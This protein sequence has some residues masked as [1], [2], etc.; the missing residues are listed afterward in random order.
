V[1]RVGGGGGVP[2]DLVLIDLIDKS[3]EA[4]LQVGR[5]IR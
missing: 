3:P 1:E 5:R 4:V 2:A